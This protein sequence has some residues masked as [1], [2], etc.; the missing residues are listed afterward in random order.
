MMPAYNA[1]KSIGRALTS[2]ILQSYKNW[3][4]IVVNDGSTDKTAEEV[5][6]I[7]DKRIILVQ[8]KAN[9]GRASARQTALEEARGDLIAYLDADDFYHPDKLR[10]QVKVMTLRTDLSLCGTAIGCFSSQG[11]LYRIRSDIPVT[12]A[13]HVYSKPLPI[14]PATCIIRAKIAKSA[15]YTVWMRY[16]EDVDYL[17]RV[18]DKSA[19]ANISD[20]LYY[21]AEFDDR[22]ISKIISSYFPGIIRAMQLIP[23]APLSSFR[24]LFRRLIALMGTGLYVATFGTEKLL[25]RR[26]RAPASEEAL[27]FEASLTAIKK[28]FFL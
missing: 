16:G 20:I 13:R 3:E 2:L 14:S 24:F 27:T 21:Y 4:V 26:G 28:K 17:Q 19:Y 23:R 10:R 9:R 11:V 12:I 22:G 8:H 1:E 18:L 7:T 25:M 5:L 6:K 15:K